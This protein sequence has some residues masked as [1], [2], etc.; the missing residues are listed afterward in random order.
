MT[1]VMP[2]PARTIADL[3]S[4]SRITY[5]N[6]E[7]LQSEILSVLLECSVPAVRE[8]KLSDGLSRID[9]MVDQIGIEVKIKGS[10]AGVFRQ[11]KRYAECPEITEL[12]LVTTR[13]KHHQVPRVIL[14]KRVTLVSLIEGGL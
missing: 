12:I 5:G 9:L 1:V 8:V 11:L 14:G 4:N 13:A 6:E 10:A 3:I 2:W 7:D